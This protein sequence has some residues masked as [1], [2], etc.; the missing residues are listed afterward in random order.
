MVAVLRILLAQVLAVSLIGGLIAIIA[1]YF[2]TGI[3]FFEI[4]RGQESNLLDL[5]GFQVNLWTA[6]LLLIA[7]LLVLAIRH[8]GQMPKWESPADII[9][10]AQNRKQEMTPK[11]GLL[12]IIASFI[13]LSG[14]ASLGQYGPLVHLGGSIGIATAKWYQ[15]FNLSRDVVIG[16]GV[17]A[18]IAAGFNAPIAAIIFAHEAVL[19]HFSARAVALISI[20]SVSA[21]ALSRLL[22]SPLDI[23][24]L[25]AEINVSPEMVAISL[26]A[27]V[28]FGISAIFI[29]KILFLVNKFAGHSQ[30]SFRFL[31]FLGLIY[32]LVLSQAL[33]EALGLGMGIINDLVSNVETTQ[34]LLILL[35]AKLSAVILSATIGFSGGFVGPALVIGAVLGALLANLAMAFGMMS[36]T[37]LLVVSGA[38]A[39]A[40]TVFG[41]PLAMV[42]LVLE[43]THSYDL[44]LAAM[45]SIIVSS[46][47]FHLFYGHSLFDLQL[48]ARGINLAK[49]RIFLE[50]ETMKMAELV[51]NDYLSFQSNVRADIIL[52]RMREAQQT[53]AYCIDEKG[54]FL[55]KISIFKVVAHDNKTA[56]QLADSDCLKLY[57]D[58][59]INEAMEVAIDFV[60]EGLPVLDKNRKKLA[61]VVSES[62]LFDAYNSVT[63]QVREIETA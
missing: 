50:L 7:Y 29:I 16:C 3:R 6:G 28:G 31:A 5:F 44:S 57:A 25:P 36:L 24:V 1:H 43:L 58:Q 34:M 30:R 19:R 33:P 40:G 48:M 63:R 11:K 12:T 35:I 39:V 61:G 46:L 59:S 15:R 54:I 56:S 22:F 60:G 23:F 41:A 62:H 38:A 42:M 17:A 10:C 53:E 21:S 47:I 45:L 8:F 55:G 27:G 32:L 14:G 20:S 2:V 9:Y 13:S 51:E 26:L 37:M 18:A 52:A 49:G 4:F